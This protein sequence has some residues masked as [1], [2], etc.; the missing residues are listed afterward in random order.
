M[1]NKRLIERKEHF[2]NLFSLRLIMFVTHVFFLRYEIL[3]CVLNFIFVE[4][5]RKIFIFMYIIERN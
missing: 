2:V 3:L 5:R 1:F 4:K